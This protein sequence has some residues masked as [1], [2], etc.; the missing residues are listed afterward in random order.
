MTLSGGLPFRGGTLAHKNKPVS[1]H[2]V[3]TMSHNPIAAGWVHGFAGGVIKMI[4][5]QGKGESKWC[6]MGRSL[7]KSPGRL[8]HRHQQRT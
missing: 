2:R 8:H 7:E 3:P 1:S 6:L 5:Y 4:S